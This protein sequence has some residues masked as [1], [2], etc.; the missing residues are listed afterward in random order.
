MF[1]AQPLASS[2]RRGRGACSSCEPG[3]VRLGTRYASALP[4]HHAGVP[5]LCTRARPRAPLSSNRTTWLHGALHAMRALHRKLAQ[6]VAVQPWERRPSIQMQRSPYVTTRQILPDALG[7]LLRPGASRRLAFEHLRPRGTC[8][9][10]GL[11]EFALGR[12]IK[13]AGGPQEPALQCI[14]VPRA[15]RRARSRA[16]ACVLTVRAHN[17]Q[18]TRG[19]RP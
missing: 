17:W 7:A 10:G 12:H 6:A 13:R 11:R 8:V 4:A 1:T 9:R 14:A 2:V 3:A 18:R 16:P 19:M 5:S 15:L